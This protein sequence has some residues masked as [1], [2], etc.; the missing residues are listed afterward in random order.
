MKKTSFLIFILAVLLLASGCTGKGPG[1]K[2]LQVKNDTINVPDTGF[3]GIKKFTSGEYIVMEVTFKNGV[4][5]GLMKSFYKGGQ[6]RQTYWYENGLKEDSVRWYYLEGQLFRT[7]PYKHDTI[8]GIQK[9]FYRTGK[10][11]AKI[12]YSKGLRTQYIEEFTPEGRLVKDYPGLVVNIR[13][14]YSSK[15]LYHIGLELTDKSPKVKFYRGDFSDGRFD[16]TKYK[17][18]KTVEGKGMLDLKK[19]GTPKA[20]Y[21]GVFAEILTPFGNKLLTWKKIELPYKDLN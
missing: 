12:G 9:Q 15:G 2:G 6:V 16:T 3:T 1:K 11:K 5:D 4:R 14:E 21:V 7:S 20:E 10:V 17:I 13:D 8:D 18:I 19:T